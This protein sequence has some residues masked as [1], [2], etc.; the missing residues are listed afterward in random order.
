MKYSYLV[1][2]LIV[3]AVLVGGYSLIKPKNADNLPVNQESSEASVSTDS[4]ATAELN[5]T[6]TENTEPAVA[7]TTTAVKEFT[8]IAKNW[9]FQPS[10]ITVNQGDTV[11]L[12]IK[13]IDVKHGFNIPDYNI[14]V[15]LPPNEE[16]IVE[17]TA[18][19]A[20]TFNFRC[21][22]LCGEGHRAMTGQ[23]IVQ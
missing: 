19:Q 7:D 18:D 10:V 15:N 3:L 20:G 1:G 22:V 9:E 2:G 13:S 14:K 12:K 5:E 8:M 11:R 17:F 21:S 16:Q 6:V 23:L 4:E